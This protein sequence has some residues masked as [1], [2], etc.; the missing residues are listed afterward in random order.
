ML[1]GTTATKTSAYAT[2]TTAKTTVIYLCTVTNKKNTNTT[3][4]LLLLAQAKSLHFNTICTGLQTSARAREYHIIFPFV[5]EFRCSHETY[6]L[7]KHR[8]LFFTLPRR[9]QPNRRRKKNTHANSTREY[10][11]ACPRPYT[12]H[13][14]NPTQNS[15]GMRMFVCV[16]VHARG[17]GHAVYITH[18]R[19]AK[20][21]AQRF[22]VI[23]IS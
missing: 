9:I 10:F 17:L 18:S 12:L 3:H 8:H 16:C 14:T 4:S 6:S 19:T 13:T 20:S 1:I 21:L 7:F 23:S 2:T 11:C 5:N 22:Q 15:P